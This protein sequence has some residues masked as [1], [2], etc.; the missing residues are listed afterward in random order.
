MLETSIKAQ[1]RNAASVESQRKLIAVLRQLPS[2][3]ATTPVDNKKAAYKASW[4]HHPLKQQQMVDEIKSGRCKAIGV[5]CGTLSGGLLFVDHDG[6]SCE[7]LIEKLSDGQSMP[8]T[9]SVTSGRSG[10]Y[11]MIYQ[12]PRQY[13]EVIATKKLKTGKVGSDGS[14]EQLELRWNGCQSVIAGAHPITGAYHWLLGSSP[15]ECDV[16]EAPAWMIAQMLVDQRADTA[17]IQQPSFIDI[18]L[19]HCLSLDSRGLIDHGAREGSRNDSG[20]KLA[21]DLLGTAAYLDSVGQPYAGDPEAIFMGWCRQVRL[22]KD[23]PARQPESIWKSAQRSN[24][25]PCLSPDKIDNC[26][27]AWEHKQ[28]Q[29]KPEQ[30]QPVKSNNRHSRNSNEKTQQLTPDQLINRV[31]EIRKLNDGVKQ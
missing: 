7:E 20:A 30:P 31:S 12:V 28:K 3:W 8:Q 18:P 9:V 14:F 4:Q 2:A 29:G 1:N 21:R 11:Q 17:S 25:K 19:Y 5:L 23:K 15:R 27:S 26:I 6:A 16:A 22:D 13:W 24:P 10:H